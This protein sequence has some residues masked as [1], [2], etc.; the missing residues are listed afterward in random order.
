MLERLYGGLRGAAR[1]LLRR[2]EPGEIPKEYL[3][4]FLP[5]DPV[6][7]EAGA[8]IGADTLALARLWPAGVV[9]AFEPV[10]E[11]FAQLERRTRGLA[12]VCRYPLALSGSTGTAEMHVSS[13]AS[14]GS[15]SLLAP[16]GHLREHPDVAFSSRIVVPTDTLDD[17]AARE[18]I[19]RVDFLWLDMQ[20]HELNVLRTA[21]RV[22]ATVRAIHTEVSLKP[23][24]AGGPLYPELR[25]WLEERGFRVEREELPWADGG[26]VLFVRRD[27]KAGG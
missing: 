25:A 20:G 9:H 7:V 18:G 5:P 24:Y 26:N 21:P 16:D 15:S 3:H 22:L 6:V 19:A 8:H 23:L 10:P 17:W 4:R 2:P 12:N 27:D 1:R 11:L 13:G 14:D